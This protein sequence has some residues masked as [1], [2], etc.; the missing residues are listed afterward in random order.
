MDLDNDD[1]DV[2]E[3]ERKLSLM[4][5][6][7]LCYEIDEYFSSK[8]KI[9]VRKYDSSKIFTWRDIWPYHRQVYEDNY[10]GPVLTK[11]QHR[12]TVTRHLYKEW[13]K[14]YPAMPTLPLQLSVE[15]YIEICEKLRPRIMEQFGTRKKT[16]H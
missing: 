13:M 1:D 2:V 4:E 14:S 7:L 12:K 16:N 3:E 9:T 10:K 15:I 5:T 11:D 6:Q 8:N